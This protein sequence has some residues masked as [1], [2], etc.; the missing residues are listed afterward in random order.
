MTAQK[1]AASSGLSMVLWMIALAFAC[2]VLGKYYLTS[3]FHTHAS[4]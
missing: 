4:T 3:P 2:G 1:M